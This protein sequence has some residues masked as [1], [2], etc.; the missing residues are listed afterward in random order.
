LVWSRF[1]GLLVTLAQAVLP[2]S[3]EIDVDAAFIPD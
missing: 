3:T 2:S 1:D